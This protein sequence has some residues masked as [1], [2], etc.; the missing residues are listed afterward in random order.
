MTIIKMTKLEI[1]K[2]SKL[3]PILRFYTVICIL[4]MNNL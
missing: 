2:I 4:I 3:N 1:Q